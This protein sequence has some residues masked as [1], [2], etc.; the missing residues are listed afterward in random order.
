MPLNCVFGLLARPVKRQKGRAR[1]SAS[2]V[3]SQAPLRS[4]SAQWSSQASV[5]FAALHTRNRS[6]S[7]EAKTE[8]FSA[9][10]LSHTPPTH[11]SHAHHRQP[12]SAT[13]ARRYDSS[14]TTFSPEG[15]FFASFLCLFDCL[16][17]PFPPSSCPTPRPALLQTCVHVPRQPSAVEEA[18]S[19]VSSDPPS[20]PPFPPL[21]RTKRPSAPSGVRH[22]GHQQR[23]DLRGHPLYR[24]D[25][26]GRGTKDHQQAFG[27][28]Q[29][30]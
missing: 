3:W 14:T 24:R 13:M 9:C 12:H 17:P 22:R 16:P 1:K 18:T 4:K 2:L 15:T 7:E 10:T 11:P 23:R 26:L 8:C 19:R 6:R 21:P 28:L 5:V 20:F 29:V 30:Q 27:A 25:C